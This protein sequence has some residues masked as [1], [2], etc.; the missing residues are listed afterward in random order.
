[1]KKILIILIFFSN[2]IFANTWETQQ[3]N[4]TTNTTIVEVVNPIVRSGKLDIRQAFICPSTTLR[5]ID[6]INNTVIESKQAHHE[7]KK[8]DNI[9]YSTGSYT[10]NY[11]TNGKLGFSHT[12]LVNDYYQQ[13]LEE[14][15]LR[16]YN[17]ETTLGFNFQQ[18]NQDISSI[19]ETQTVDVD[20]IITDVGLKNEYDNKDFQTYSQMM[21]NI[22]TGDEQDIIGTNVKGEIEF[23]SD[24]LGQSTNSNDVNTDEIIN[25]NYDSDEGVFSDDFNLNFW[26]KTLRFFGISEENEAALDNRN[27]LLSNV[28]STDSFIN[29]SILGYYHNIFNV[30]I[31]FGFYTI[32]FALILS[33]VILQHGFEDLSNRLSA[34]K[35]KLKKDFILFS[36]VTSILSIFVFFSWGET[37]VNGKIVDGPTGAQ[38]AISLF[39]DTSTEIADELLYNATAMRIKQLANTSKVYNKQQL[40]EITKDIATNLNVTSQQI[41]VLQMCREIYST[42]NESFINF[43]LVS[44][45]NLQ[46]DMFNRGIPSINT[47]SSVEKSI[48][49]NMKQIEVDSQLLTQKI[50]SLKNNSG[51]KSAVEI[52]IGTTAHL[53]SS[54]IHSFGWMG[55]PLYYS[56]PKYFENLALGLE[57]NAAAELETNTNSYFSKNEFTDEDSSIIDTGVDM[58]SAISSYIFLSSF[59]GYNRVQQQLYSLMRPAPIS[60]EISEDWNYN[61]QETAQNKTKDKIQKSKKNIQKVKKNIKNKVVRFFSK[62]TPAGAAASIVDRTI[63]KVISVGKE[64]TALL[65]SHMGAKVAFINFLKILK[66]AGVVMLIIIMFGM[67]LKEIFVLSVFVGFLFMRYVRGAITGNY[68]EASTFALG[69]ILYIFIYPIALVTAV[70][71]L[72]FLEEFLN[73]LFSFYVL[74]EVQ[75]LKTISYSLS[76]SQGVFDSLATKM[77]S[78]LLIGTLA[79]VI[80]IL[81]LIALF[82][83]AYYVIISM[84]KEITDLI[85]SDASSKSHETALNTNHRNLEGK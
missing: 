65:L 20:E 8:V 58:T 63:S 37:V 83:I 9:S 5:L 7:L 68:S 48:F 24:T 26:D 70:M 76:A 57:D 45:R 11:S 34:N 82:P 36:I 6:T 13:I 19:K 30:E 55:L 51:K 60:D 28:D 2:I 79:G 75:S 74:L 49:S 67:Y 22:I 10:C 80:E 59:D 46:H 77:E 78:L 25:S 53:M 43:E 21:I 52:A 44:Y 66:Y 3:T 23:K 12:Y 39:A 62:L 32:I 69:K 56:L 1:M 16:I 29:K 72:V 64:G 33:K 31:S 84:P 81:K 61:A 4:D 54:T 35:Q 17:G 47:C 71:F 73:Y 27:E 15:N 42:P 14:K 18:L 85:D 40:E 50:K 41:S 38:T